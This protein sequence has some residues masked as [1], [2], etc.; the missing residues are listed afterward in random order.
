MAGSKPDEEVLCA[1]VAADC[2]RD[3]GSAGGLAPNAR[4]ATPPTPLVLPCATVCSSGGG[5]AFKDAIETSGFSAM[6]LFDHS[7]N[8][9]VQY[10]G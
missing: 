9:L 5:S 1:K 2:A 4:G 7:L 6:D 10:L 8:T 3:S